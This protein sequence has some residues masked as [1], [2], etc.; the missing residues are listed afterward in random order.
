MLSSYDDFFKLKFSNVKLYK[1][2]KD[3]CKTC[4]TYA[5]RCKDPSLSADDKTDNEIRHSYHLAK[6]EAGYGLHKTLQT[7]VTESTMFLSMDLQQALPTPK[8]TTGIALY[9]IKMWTNSFNIRQERAIWSSVMKFRA[10]GVPS[11]CEVASLSFSSEENDD[12]LG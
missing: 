6:A 11:N 12:V 7:G 4:D 9:K 2:R 10:R 1:P 8:V 3:T 5:V